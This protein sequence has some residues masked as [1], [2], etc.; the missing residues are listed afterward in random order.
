MWPD[1]WKRYDD[2]LIKGVTDHVEC[3]MYLLSVGL[4]SNVSVDSKLVS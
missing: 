4:K 3:I 1:N 2:N